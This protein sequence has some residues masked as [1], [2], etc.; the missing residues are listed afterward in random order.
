MKY[1]CSYLN[2]FNISSFLLRKWK[3]SSIFL[4]LFQFYFYYNFISVILKILYIKYIHIYPSIHP[5][6][7][8][9]PHL[10]PTRTQLFLCFKFTIAKLLSSL[11]IFRT[12]KYKYFSILS[13]LNIL[14]MENVLKQNIVVHFLKC[15]FLVFLD[16]G[17]HKR[18]LQK[19]RISRSAIIYT[20][21][22]TFHNDLLFEYCKRYVLDH[23]IFLIY[24]EKKRYWNTLYFSS[25]YSVI[26]KFYQN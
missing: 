7:R 4:I 6:T 23:F 5:P 12:Y 22:G 9:H 16:K 2:I 26:W 20:N 11:E 14:F 19:C 25:I 18:I 1:L 8:T 10:S 13:S 21:Y 24:N 17:I 3:R 15:I